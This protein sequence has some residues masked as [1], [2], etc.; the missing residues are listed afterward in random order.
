MNLKLLIGLLVFTPIFAFS[1]YGEQWTSSEI[2]HEIQKL[3]TLGRVLYIAA[4]PDDE[5]TRL[6][7]HL[8][9]K[10]RL[11][12][13]Y[14]SLT[15]GDGGQNLIGTEIGT[16]LGLIRTQE[17]LAARRTDGG[18]QFFSR[19]LD[20]GYSKSPEES[21]RFWDK[22]EILD[23]VVWVIRKFQPD[24]I[25]NRF[26]HDGYNGHG[27]HTASAM[28]SIE[29]F[30]LA[31]DPTAFPHQLE[32]VEPW[33]ARQ[34]WHNVSTWWDKELPKRAE[35][36]PE[37]I[38]F[39]VSDFEP[40]LGRSM[41]EIASISRSQHSSQGFGTTLQRGSNVEY[42]KW[43]KGAEFSE[44]LFLESDMRWSSLNGGRAIED[45]ITAVLQSLNPQ[46]PEKSVAGLIEVA[47]A[48]EA[49]PESRF[50]AK[51]LHHV[52]QI[53]AQCAGIWFEA[54]TGLYEVLPGDHVKI[55]LSFLNRSALDVNLRGFSLNQFDTT[56]TKALDYN[57]THL[58]PVDYKV[59][60]NE[61]Y[62]EQ[63]WL[64]APHI[65]GRFIVKDQQL[66]GL[67]ESDWPFTVKT[68]VEIQGY[69]MVVE[70]PVIHKW[71]DRAKG[72]QIRTL[73]V[74]PAISVNP[75]EAVVMALNQQPAKLS[76]KVK[77]HS[78]EQ[79]GVLR[80]NLPEGWTSEPEVIR[81]EL[82]RR[83]EEKF[84]SFNITPSKKAKDGQ[85]TVVAETPTGNFD[86]QLKNITYDHIP[87]QQVLYKSQ[88]R[89]VSYEL[90]KG[91]NNIG[92][93][94]GSGDDVPDA[95]RAMGYNVTLLSVGDV[96][97]ADLSQY[98]AV[99]TGIRAYN[100]HESLAGVNHRLM[101]YVEQGGNMIVQYN[102]TYGLPVGDI[103]PHPFRISRD[104]VTDEDA[105]P[106]FLN[107]KHP[108]LN[109]PN[110]LTEADFDGWVQE[111]GLYFA[112]EWDPAF[113]PIISWHDQGEDPVKGALIVS[114]YGK[115][116]F[117]YTG[118]SF[119]RELPA[120]VPGAY[121]LLANIIA[122]QQKDGRR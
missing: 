50:K 17:L 31:A 33:Q 36:D 93:L 95:L 104:R 62:T 25:I 38:A 60:E 55:D 65:E 73:S 49:M 100:V 64:K 41:G 91:P 110:K 20:F 94:E 32:Y 61:P 5:N 85:V 71:A 120:G 77:S 118:I 22:Q 51:K 87:T 35:S 4:H 12:V 99:I 83:H 98:D 84:Y 43:V 19:A 26:A 6:I 59:P 13:A 66:R 67:P 10:E 14:L 103:G 27:H 75:S 34:L 40:L 18:S 117:T 109:Q 114:D 53:I 102:V 105:Q 15:R 107:K 97:S 81:F 76:V 45:K 54:N 80:V 1:Q 42:L 74:V 7:A 46:A 82:N 3:N 58:I 2:E 63:Y 52:Q 57:K 113:E 56:F 48:I 115:G 9:N 108:I 119:F 29:A 11:D 23:D 111:R 106:K 90:D 116:T 112:D 47:Q 101:E 28:L 24:V 21:F 89:A 96:G 86:Q 37:I 16:E 44:D 70:T 122:Y 30:E 8:S 68:E 78:P 121:R 72:E 69:S 92:Y 39:E 79:A 88:V